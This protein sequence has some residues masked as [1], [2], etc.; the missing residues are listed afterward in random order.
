MNKNDIGLVLIVLILVSGCVT[1][2][3]VTKYIDTKCE[4]MKFNG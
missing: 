3:V 2:N 1:Q 4:E